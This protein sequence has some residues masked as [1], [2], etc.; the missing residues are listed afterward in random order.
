MIVGQDISFCVQVTVDN[1]FLASGAASVHESCVKHQQVL[2]AQNSCIDSNTEDVCSWS[3][4]LCHSTRAGLLDYTLLV[5]QHVRAFGLAFQAW[6][7]ELTEHV[8]SCELLPGLPSP[9]KNY[10]RFHHLATAHG[11]AWLH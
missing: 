6:P 9:R 7:W 4:P 2:I 11:I 3:I 1:A 8:G 10:W 5:L